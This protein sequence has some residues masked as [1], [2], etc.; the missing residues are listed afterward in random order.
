MVKF[1]H[2]IFAMPFAILGF[3]LAIKLNDLSF[4]YAKLIY[5]VFA[6]IFARNAAMGFNRYLDRDIDKKND[7]TKTREVAAGIITAKNALI[8]VIINSILFIATAWFINLLAFA[9]S[10][11]ALAVVLGYS[12]TK[13][14][15]ALCHLVLGLGLSLA[16]IGAYISVTGAFNN[17]IP[18][19]ISFVVLF[20]TAGFDIIYALQDE[21]FDNENHLKSIPSLIGKKKSLN[22]SAGFH[23]IS[24]ILVI[25]VGYLLGTGIW[26]WIAAAFFIGLLYNQHRL[27]KPDNLS[28]VNM[29]FFTTNGFASILYAVFSILSLYIH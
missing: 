9:L 12:F 4:D 29:A 16:P 26:Y 5:I 27:V 22:L 17:I 11:I 21:D 25:T 13:R 15:T 14:F 7:R 23:I 8:F 19:L 6:M 18:I 24:A 1:A 20:W 2:S 28:K 3:F 10:P